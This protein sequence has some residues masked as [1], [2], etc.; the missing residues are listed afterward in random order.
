[1]NALRLLAALALAV[2]VQSVALGAQNANLVTIRIQEPLTASGNANKYKTAISEAL[3][4][5][6]IGRL[7]GDG[8][9]EGDDRKSY[10]IDI[11]LIDPQ[12]AIP[13]LKQELRN[14]GVPQGTLLIYHQGGH[15]IWA[16]VMPSARPNALQE[17]E[18]PSNSY[19]QAKG[20]VD[21]FKT[22]SLTFFE[23]EGWLALEKVRGNWRLSR[24]TL[25]HDEFG[26]GYEPCKFPPKDDFRLYFHVKELRDGPINAA[27]IS[28][29]IPRP[30]DSSRMF[31]ESYDRGDQIVSGPAIE[32]IFQ[33]DRYRFIAEKVGA[34]HHLLLTWKS[35][36]ADFGEIV[37]DQKVFIYWAGDLNRDNK[38]DIVISKDQD[39]ILLLSDQACYRLVPIGESNNYQI[40]QGQR[41]LVP[42]QSVK[43]TAQLIR[44]GNPQQTKGH[45][46]RE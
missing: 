18:I 45:S 24:L 29:I 9:R 20:T 10:T 32:M 8:I 22:T 16:S 3:A 35:G 17:R 27:R 7:V 39:P 28:P 42:H 21:N 41:R 23:K 14:L 43:R 5:Q 38:F 46:V 30:D 12:R 33:G 2:L 25:C 1:M 31:Y 6:K 15:E 40:R 19:E 37:V 44:C 26:G 11:E 4:K 13:I 36:F 34:S